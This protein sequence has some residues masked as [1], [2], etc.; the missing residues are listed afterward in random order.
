MHTLEA[1][2]EKVDTSKLATLSKRHLENLELGTSNFETC[3]SVDSSK[4]N[5]STFK[6]SVAIQSRSISPMD[7]Q[8]RRELFPPPKVAPRPVRL[9]S[10]SESVNMD[11][12]LQ[13]PRHRASTIS[14]LGPEANGTA[15]DVSSVDARPASVVIMEHQRDMIQTSGIPPRPL[16]VASQSSLFSRTQSPAS[17]MMTPSQESPVEM[18]TVSNG[19][20]GVLQ[21]RPKPRRPA[22]PRPMKNGSI[23]KQYNG[24]SPLQLAP[25]LSPVSGPPPPPPRGDSLSTTKSSEVNATPPISPPS[26]TSLFSNDPPTLSSTLAMNPL[27]ASPFSIPEDTGAPTSFGGIPFNSAAAVTPS[28][29]HAQTSR[30]KPRAPL[31]KQGSLYISPRK[32]SIMDFTQLTLSMPGADGTDNKDKLRASQILHAGGVSNSDMSSDRDDLLAAIRKGLQLK[33]VEKEE[34]EKKKA[35]E[36]MPWDVAAI[37]ERRLAIES[38]SEGSQEGID[39]AEWED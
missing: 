9:S 14:S 8:P 10:Q 24:G 12:S 38:D 30:P 15:K 13:P 32:Q 20:G 4:K 37:L 33:K 25:N 27:H 26:S 17:Q 18:L 1:E 22:P 35:S 21:T 19:T 36:A 7:L 3:L 5:S 2:K 28:T 31:L 29:F 39:D 11:P 16:S 6:A 34:Q 23:T